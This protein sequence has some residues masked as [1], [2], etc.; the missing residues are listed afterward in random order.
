MVAM[1]RPPSESNAAK[2]VMARQARI[3]EALRTARR[4]AGLSVIAV[5]Y[6]AGVGAS[7][8]ERIEAGGNVTLRT[9]LAVAEVVGVVV[10]AT[11]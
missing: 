3:G 5:A 8:V 9:V 6:R 11:P 4:H 1:L 10:E 2:M 7:T